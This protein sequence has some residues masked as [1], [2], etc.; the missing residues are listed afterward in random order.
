MVNYNKD[1]FIPKNLYVTNPT[2]KRRTS[3]VEVS[4][5]LLCAGV[6]VNTFKVKGIEHKR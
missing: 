1:E 5:T 4:K 3:M 2:W 6:E